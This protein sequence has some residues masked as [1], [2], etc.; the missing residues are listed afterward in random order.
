MALW[1]QDARWRHR[2]TESDLHFHLAA[3]FESDKRIADGR[4]WR[5][6][7]GSSLPN[8]SWY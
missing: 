6:R 2:D 4:P 1:P 3:S 7:A 8:Y 5:Q